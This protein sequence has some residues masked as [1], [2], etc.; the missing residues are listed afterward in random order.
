M[1]KWTN[2]TADPAGPI[3]V[4]KFNRAWSELTREENMF[5]ELRGTKGVNEYSSVL[6]VMCG[7]SERTD[8]EEVK[9]RLGEQYA[10]TVSRANHKDIIA[11]IE[12][13]LV[14]IKKNRPVKDER[15]TPDEDAAR[16]A[17]YARLEAERKA[18]E[19]ARNDLFVRLYG[20][21][22][23]RTVEPGYMA[24]TATLCYDGSDYM[25]DYFNTHAHL[26][27]P[28]ALMVVPKGAETERIA[29]A[30]LSCYP[31]FNGIDFVWKTEKYSMGHGNYLTSKAFEL[32]EELKGLKK[33]YAGGEVTHGH[34]EIEF[35]RAYSQPETMP[36]FKLA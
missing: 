14:D 13:E 22:S 26:S 2:S 15:T 24:V 27:E 17:E 5:V 11:G 1:A 31:I 12:F 23:T 30:A 7:K 33:A 35:K 9:N 6:W 32:P 28:F 3:Q 18:K 8:V 16:N 25:S 36:A 4:K 10:W 19:A 29:R 34:W 20:D 21:G